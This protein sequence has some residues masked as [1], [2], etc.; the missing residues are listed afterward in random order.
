M[1]AA[2]WIAKRRKEHA[3]AWDRS[4]M[5]AAYDALPRAL[6]AL[7]AVLELHTAAPGGGWCRKCE[8]LSDPYDASY[9]CATRRAIEDKLEGEKR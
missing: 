2:E 5:I 7:E 6:D 3:Q 9:P 8:T 4:D 1:S